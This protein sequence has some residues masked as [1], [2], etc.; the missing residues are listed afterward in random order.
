[1]TFLKWMLKPKGLIVLICLHAICG[2]IAYKSWEAGVEWVSGM[3]GLVL[4]LYWVG[5]AYYYRS[6]LKR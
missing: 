4:G 1:M 3:M 2:I 5:S 6:R